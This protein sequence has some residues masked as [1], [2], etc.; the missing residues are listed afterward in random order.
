SGGQKRRAVFMPPGSAKSYYASTM[1]PAYA[2]GRQ[3]EW[4]IIQASHTQQLA[5]F[6]GRRV[7][8]LVAEPRWRA[9]FG[10]GLASDRTAVDRWELQNGA[11]YVRAGVGGALTGKRG[12]LFI[13]DEPVKS[14]EE[15]ESEIY[16]EGNWEW[17]RSDVRARMKPGCRIVLIQTRWHF[18]DLAGRILPEN[19][20]FRSGWVTAR[21][22]E[23]WYVLSL[24]A[25]ADRPDD[26]LG[27]NIG[28]SIWP[29]WF[30]Q[31]MLE[32]ER[33]SQ[34]PRNWASLYQQ[35]P[36]PDEG[37]YFER[38]DF[39]YCDSPPVHL[40]VYGASDY[41]VSEKHGDSTVHLVVGVD[42]A[43]NIYLLDLVREQK[44]TIDWVEDPLTLADRYRDRLHVWAEEKDQIE[45]S[46][47]PFL[48]KR[49]VER[50][51]YFTRIQ[52]ASGG[53]KE[54]KAPAIQARMQ[55]HKGLLSDLTT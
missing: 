29:E 55:L 17:F 7:R 37:G 52:Y 15:A 25:L 14:D 9:A 3:P 12:D 5:D 34:G 43:D 10:I 54:L 39:R 4:N 42:P 48:K 35:R 31:T 11:E 28:E 23:E 13:I 51:I 22:G 33:I 27:R 6:W 38:K 16:R 44:Q 8:N 41:A 20:D 19:Y 47:G 45:R 40:R 1:A 36:T 18:D 32:Q 50:G 21:D 24:P 53:D 49:Q 26:P 30:T 46:V 2:R